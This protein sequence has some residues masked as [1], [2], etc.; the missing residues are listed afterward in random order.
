MMKTFLAIVGTTAGSY[1]GWW[2]GGYGGFT[3][4]CFGS[5]VGMG[6]GL[7]ASRRLWQAYDDEYL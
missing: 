4:A 7:Y 2:L 3:F 1:V 6:I 5:V